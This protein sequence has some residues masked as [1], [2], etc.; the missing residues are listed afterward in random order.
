MFE[1]R[2]LSKDIY[3]DKVNACKK[4]FA[5]DFNIEELDKCIGLSPNCKNCIDYSI[6]SNT[7][8]HSK[9]CRDDTHPLVED[10]FEKNMNWVIPVI[11]ITGLILLALI[12]LLV[13]S[14]L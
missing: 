3:E 4:Q 11:V 13:I 14:I 10:F 6:S 1:S 12:I 2:C 9:C 7:D 5:G 8:I